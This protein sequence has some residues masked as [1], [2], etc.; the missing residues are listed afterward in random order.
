M[1][2]DA[3]EILMITHWMWQSPVV[4]LV[5]RAL[6]QTLRGGV[7]VDFF[8]VAAVTLL[9][10]LALLWI[11]RARAV[12][13]L[14]GILILGVF[15][16]VA[17]QAG[18]VLTTSLFRGL[19]TVV[20]LSLVSLF[21]EDLRRFFER[22]TVYKQDPMHRRMFQSLLRSV[23]YFSKHHIGAL[24]VLKGRDPLERHLEGGQLLDGRMSSAL[25]ESIFDPHSDGHDGA[26]IID[27]DHLKRFAVHLPL[28]KAY[29]SPEAA[30]GTRHAAALGLAELTDAF[31]LV[32]SETRGSV[33]I[34][35]DGKLVNMGDGQRLEKRLAGF[36]R[37]R[38]QTP[39]TARSWQMVWGHPMEKR[40]CACSQVWRSG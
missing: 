14:Q 15:Y 23:R 6:C 16:A 33:M 29:S 17:L 2:V 13:V 5:L 9:I 1:T 40:R 35:R 30:L 24:I 12:R 26:A 25:L 19:L 31:C 7:V 8:D 20:M 18:L 10:Y 4:F 36:L 38:F 11:H 32:V 3:V 39:A 22:L 37:Q 34:A 27:G 28:S 21:Q